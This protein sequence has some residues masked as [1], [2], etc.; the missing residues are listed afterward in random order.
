MEIII[1]SVCRWAFV[2]GVACGRVVGALGLMALGYA[3]VDY[4][5]TFSANVS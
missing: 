3:M 1:S 5:R 4:F 2:Y